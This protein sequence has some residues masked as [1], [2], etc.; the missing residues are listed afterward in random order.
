MKYK[1][2][3]AAVLVMS[4]NAYAGDYCTTLASLA[5]TTMGLRQAGVP[6][7]EVLATHD[8]NTPEIVKRLDIM[9][10][11]SPM[12]GSDKMKRQAAT[13]FSNKVYL[14]CFKKVGSK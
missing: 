6:L 4:S 8:K 12:W 13:E 2:I 1:F 5:E 10:Y 7:T 9:A 14:M 3:T 11:D